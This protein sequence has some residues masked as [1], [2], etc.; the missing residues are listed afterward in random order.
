MRCNESS[1]SNPEYALF[2]AGFRIIIMRAARGTGRRPHR[3]CFIHSSGTPL[4]SMRCSA[5]SN[6][7][8][9]SPIFARASVSSRSSGSLRLFNPR[10]PASRNTRF[11]ASSSGAGTWPRATWR[12]G[13]RPGAV[14]ARVRPSAVYSTVQAS[15][16][17]SQETPGHCRSAASSLAWRPSPS[18]LVHHLRVSPD[19]VPRNSGP[20]YPPITFPARS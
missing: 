11:H 4:S 16:R 10:A 7:I 18:S 9:S 5:S 20:V 15:H 13:P 2:H 6:L 14:S 19:G 8:I 12:R 17:R 3:L 1:E